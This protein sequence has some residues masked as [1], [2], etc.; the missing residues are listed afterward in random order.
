MHK[1]CFQ[2]GMAYG[3]FKYWSRRT[4]SDK[5]LCNKAIN[6]AENSKN[7]GYQRDLDSMGYKFFDKK[8][9]G[10]GVMSNQQLAEELHKPIIKKNEKRKV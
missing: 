1:A 4:V 9:S 7:D 3:D 6:I 2:H 8:S 5:F 10:S